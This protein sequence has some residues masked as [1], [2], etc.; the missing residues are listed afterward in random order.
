MSWRSGRPSLLG[1]WANRALFERF[2]GLARGIGAL[3]PQSSVH[4]IPVRQVPLLFNLRNH[5][6]C[7]AHCDHGG[8]NARLQLNYEETK[9]GSR[10]MATPLVWQIR[11]GTAYIPQESN[12]NS[13]RV[14]C[15]RCRTI[16]IRLKVIH[17]VNDQN[18]NHRLVRN[19]PPT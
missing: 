19:Q 4:M 14:A 9:A 10:R 15:V 8:E 17:R 5:L 13:R 7:T 1:G 3:S 12:R 2:S 16:S 6:P 18:C 11:F